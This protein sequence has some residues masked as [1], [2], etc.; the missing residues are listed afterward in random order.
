MTPKEEELQQERALARIASLARSGQRL[1]DDEAQAVGLSYGD[2]YAMKSQDNPFHTRDATCFVESKAA[3]QVG[4]RTFSYVWSTETPDHGGDI[5]KA[6]GW[7]LSVY[8]KNP[9]ALWGHDG[10]SR[11]PIGRGKNVRKGDIGNGTRGL[12]GEIELAPE[13]ASEFTDALYRF[14]EADIVRA[15]S[16]GFRAMSVKEVRSDKEREKLGLGKWGVYFDKAMLMEISLVSL[17]QN[18]EALGK[19]AEGFLS[20][21]NVTRKG[22]EELIGTWNSTQRDKDRLV[23]DLCK[24]IHL[25]APPSFSAPAAVEEIK[26]TTEEQVASFSAVADALAKLEEPAETLS[27]APS[28]EIA[29]ETTEEPAE[30]A[31]ADTAQEAAPADS[32]VD[33]EPLPEDT[34]ESYSL[35]N[36]DG[37]FKDES[38][39][40][41]KVT[42]KSSTSNE[43]NDT[44]AKAV[45]VEKQLSELRS[46]CETQ[47]Q[48][49]EKQDQVISSLGDLVERLSASR[50][51]AP[52][53]D[54][55]AERRGF[56]RACEELANI[57]AATAANETTGA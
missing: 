25:I 40:C 32:P 35:D 23:A 48:I 27:A 22:I 57:A 31:E 37:V 55:S 38:G 44:T 43:L 34:V 49:T 5:V 52:V 7:D 29:P 15:T 54:E 33:V 20:A 8:K 16:V 14:V 6:S 4:E 28:E 47:K 53:E 13:G 39:N 36:C 18:P 2:V 11:P 41:F 24:K 19:A 9:V 51:S 56:L 46:I 17:P 42:F 50:T 21:G 45:E 10:T 1:T 30:P 26:Q 12:V 3:K